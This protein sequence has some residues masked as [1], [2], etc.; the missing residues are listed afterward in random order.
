MGSATF[1]LPDAPQRGYVAACVVARDAHVD[2][3][4]WVHYHLKLGIWP[5]YVFDHGSIPPMSGVLS[6][7]VQSKTVVYHYFTTFQHATEK[8]QLYAYDRCLKEYGAK[9]TWIA[10][11]DVDE[12][13]VFKKGPPVQSLPSLLQL[14]EPY[15][16][17]AVHWI[18]FGSS[19]Y[20]IRPSKGVLRSYYKCLPLEHDQHLFI[21]TIANT[22]CTLGTSHSPHVFIHN[23][24]TPVVRTD[25][26]PV[27]GPKASNVMHDT[28]ALHH[29]A[30][31]SEEEFL[32]KMARGSGMKRQ[33]GWE[34]FWFV[35][36]WSTD[37]NF[38]VMSVWDDDAAFQP[39]LGPQA[40]AMQLEAYENEEHE[41]F[42]NKGA[43]TMTN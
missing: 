18:L 41:Q 37:F 22:K 6:S 7:Y 9:H 34:Y 21:K 35:D 42:W 26:S 36:K 24:S 43:N 15:S 8:P 32:V 16:A 4:E 27:T 30:I 17:L 28:L 40:L 1:L 23:C 14:Y 13:L 5:I 11:L 20:T 38:D 29:Y 31:K 3:V 39:L 2:I 19:G 33:R 25:V 12:F 10:F